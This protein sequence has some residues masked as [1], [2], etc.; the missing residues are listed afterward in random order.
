MTV[1]TLKISVALQSVFATL[2]ILFFLLA[3]GLMTR[4]GRRL[5]AGKE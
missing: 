2:T 3:I 4:P 5:Q 1:G